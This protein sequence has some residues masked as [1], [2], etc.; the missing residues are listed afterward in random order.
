MSI[1]FT[2]A[3]KL[4]S[5]LTKKSYLSS[6][7]NTEPPINNL[8]DLN[9]NSK[10]EIITNYS[11]SNSLALTHTKPR[12]EVVSRL[13]LNLNLDLAKH[14]FTSAIHNTII[15]IGNRGLEPIVGLTGTDQILCDKFQSNFKKKYFIWKHL[16][17][18][19][20][21]FVHKFESDYKNN[22]YLRLKYQLSIIILNATIS[23]IMLDIDI[24]P[25]INIFMSRLSDNSEKL[26]S[27]LKEIKKL[28][29]DHEK[30]L[31]D[32][33]KSKNNEISAEKKLIL[34]KNNLS[35]MPLSESDIAS[36]IKI[37]ENII[38]LS[39]KTISELDS[40]IKKVIVDIE[41][42]TD[43]F[44]SCTTHIFDVIKF[45]YFTTDD[46]FTAIDHGIGN[47][48]FPRQ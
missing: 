23:Y 34:Q 5:F 45:D 38:L 2:S 42:P 48:L 30:Y 46:Y 10:S 1:Q 32:T 8:C 35:T 36:N 24:R 11:H 39:K 47:Y 27:L 26:D 6:V 31:Y 28:E 15:E 40:K 18:Q 21:L 37:Q 19:I 9:F 4:P 25:Q 3:T 44:N 17:K 22:D 41:K 29:I 33:N 13:N 7:T 20:I 43:L 12:S 14:P 16:T